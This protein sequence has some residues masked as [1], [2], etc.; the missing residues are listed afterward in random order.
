MDNRRTTIVINKPFQYQYSLLVVA[1]AVLMINALII[2][3][4]LFPELIPGMQAVH[5][6]MR[7]AISVAGVELILIAAIWYGCLKTTHRIAGP[8]HV[9]A[10]EIQRLG[11]GDLNV[12]IMLREG[13]MFLPEAE[14][15]NRSIAALRS[16]IVTIQTLVEQ[17]HQ[18]H[19]TGAAVDTIVA[20]LRLELSMFAVVDTI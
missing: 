8:V 5:L 17:L 20:Q 18:A 19:A 6:S 16:R 11:M 2:V 4:M 13:D 12:R 3:R 9:F 15:M 10:R 14:R 1:L 7:G